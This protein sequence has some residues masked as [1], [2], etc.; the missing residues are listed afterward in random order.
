[1]G[2]KVSL[3]RDWSRYARAL[4]L[5]LAGHRLGDIGTELGVT[6]ERAR[7]MVMVAQRRLAYR[8]FKGAS[9]QNWKWQGT[10]WRLA[11]INKTKDAL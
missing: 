11:E 5:R 1:M 7:Q 2:G 4:D 3:R 6:R 10:H 8:V 9:K